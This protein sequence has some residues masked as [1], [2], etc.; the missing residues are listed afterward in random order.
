MS[1]ED[2]EMFASMIAAAIGPNAREIPKGELTVRSSL[3]PCGSGQVG[4]NLFNH[5]EELLMYC[6]HRCEKP[7]RALL[8][9][10]GET[11]TKPG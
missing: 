4:Y 3:C 6:C 2:E 8:K 11:L 7:R 1:A 10:D 9:D 5:K